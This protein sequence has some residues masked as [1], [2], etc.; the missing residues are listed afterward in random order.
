M[1]FSSP[2]ET[3]TPVVTIRMESQHRQLRLMIDTGGPDAMLFQSRM[4]D[5]T[6]FQTLQK[7]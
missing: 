7:M 1:S 3:D 6:G 4:S 5:S 2:F